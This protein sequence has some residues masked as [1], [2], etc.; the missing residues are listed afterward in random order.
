[1][2]PK[3][4]IISAGSFPNIE[5]DLKENDLCIACDAG[6]KYAQQLGILPDLIVGDFDSAAEAGA[7]VTRGI[8]EIALSDPDRIVRLDV[9]KDDTDTLRAVR[10]GLSK[11][12]KKFYLYGALGGR[13]LDHSLANIQT[14]LFIK[15]NGGTG[16]IMTGDTMLM[17]AENETIHF[18]RGNTGFVSAFSLSEVSRGVTIKGLMYSLE[19]GTL[20]NDFPLGVSNEFIIDEEAEITVKDGTL[21]ITVFWGQ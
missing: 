3:C 14:L 5:I 8:E 6:F 16:Y 7:D 20:T 18:H 9:K 21:L 12:Y 19:D 4:V 11:G 15:R 1:M 2:E 13:R 10:I 17:V